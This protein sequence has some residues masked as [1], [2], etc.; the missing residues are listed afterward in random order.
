LPPFESKTETDSLVSHR[1]HFYLTYLGVSK[2]IHYVVYRFAQSPRVAFLANDVLAFEPKKLHENKKSSKKGGNKKPRDKQNH[3]N[4]SKLRHLGVDLTQFT[5]FVE[6][7]WV[8]VNYFTEAGLAFYVN[9]KKKGKARVQATQFLRQELV[10]KMDQIRAAILNNTIDRLFPTPS[11]PTSLPVF[12]PVPAAPE[13]AERKEAAINP[14]AGDQLH[15]APLPV[16]VAPALPLFEPL[17]QL[18][19][20]FWNLRPSLPLA[21]PPA[22][23]IPSVILP[24]AAP[25]SPATPSLVLPPAESLATEDLETYPFSHPSWVPEPERLSIESLAS[26][27]MIPVGFDLECDFTATSQPSAAISA[28]A[29]SSSSSAT[30]SA[31]IIDDID[32][33][34]V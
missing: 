34:L 27:E 10:E 3:R 21:T 9:L 12:P 32:Q 19:P 16:L 15:A 20:T 5:D 29:F 2:I 28:S 18:P 4:S 23:V 22:P 13:E 8:A 7:R 30:S 33:Y 31:D 17:T 1:G 6:P 26:P 11:A 25:L 14:W 24:L